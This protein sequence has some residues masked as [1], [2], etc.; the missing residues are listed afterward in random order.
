[1]DSFKIKV[2]IK[3]LPSYLLFFNIYVKIVGEVIQRFE[4]GCH[5]YANHI[6]LC[7]KLSKDTIEI[8]KILNCYLG[9]ILE[10]M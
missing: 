1:M 3:T 7:C 9:T 2:L 6:Q 10:W 8:V 4:L 5:Q